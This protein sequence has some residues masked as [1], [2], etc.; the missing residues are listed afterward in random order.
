VNNI[1]LL[2]HRFEQRTTSN[3][4]ASALASFQSMQ[5]GEL[6]IS[7]SHVSF[8]G[9]SKSF[10]TKSP[11]DIQL[12]VLDDLKLFAFAVNSSL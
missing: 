12:G 11:T 6:D 5:A 4:H 8:L 9:K 7:P 1:L 2:A 10:L 3:I